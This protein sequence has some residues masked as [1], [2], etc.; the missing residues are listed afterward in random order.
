M[1]KM[2]FKPGLYVEE[3]GEEECGNRIM[4]PIFLCA[5]KSAHI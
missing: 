1:L 5:G 2:L 4:W 3:L